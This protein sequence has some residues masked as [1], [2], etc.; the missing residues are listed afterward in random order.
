MSDVKIQIQGVNGLEKRILKV[1]KDA[2]R[3]ACLSQEAMGDIL[4]IS[5]GQYGHI[6]TGRTKLTVT[7]L[8]EICSALNIKV[9]LIDEN[10]I[11]N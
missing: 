2:R 8:L 7:A 4:K 3:S 10:K 5:R 11:L 1:I 9:L 6:E